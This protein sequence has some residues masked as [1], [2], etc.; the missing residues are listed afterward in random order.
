MTHRFHVLLDVLIYLSTTRF[1]FF[2]LIVVF[3]TNK[4]ELLHQ[5]TSIS[6]FVSFLPSLIESAV[7]T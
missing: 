1:Y 4:N 5:L 2:L 6:A 3:S 7:D